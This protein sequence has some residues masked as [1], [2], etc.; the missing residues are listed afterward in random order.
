MTSQENYT[1]NFQA[2]IGD[3]VILAD[4]AMAE[5]LELPALAEVPA[6]Q[7]GDPYKRFES[8]KPKLRDKLGVA[9]AVPVLAATVLIGMTRP[10]ADDFFGTDCGQPKRYQY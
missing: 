6:A 5:A 7:Q 9:A 1:Q 2:E 10:R 3:E 8:E 4:P